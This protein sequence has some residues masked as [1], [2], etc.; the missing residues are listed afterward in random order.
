MEFLKITVLIVGF[1]LVMPLGIFLIMK[2]RKRKCKN[3]DGTGLVEYGIRNDCDIYDC[4]V[5][6][7][8]GKVVG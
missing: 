2:P 5:C 8:V 3:C 1:F 7:G 6:K 4:P